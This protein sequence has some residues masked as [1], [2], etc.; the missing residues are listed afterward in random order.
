MRD[1]VIRSCTLSG[2]NSRS[3]SVDP[4][5]IQS[6][7]WISAL[8]SGSQVEEPFTDDNTLITEDS[9]ISKSC[10]GGRAKY[11]AKSVT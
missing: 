3:S 8:D 5:P 1:R 11:N 7:L 9:T 2:P 10:S 4:C 6:D